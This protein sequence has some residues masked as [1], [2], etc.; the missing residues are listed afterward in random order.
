MAEIIESLLKLAKTDHQRIMLRDHARMILRAANRD[1]PEKS[2][3]N[4][5]E[6]AINRILRCQGNTPPSQ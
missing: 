2:D 1:I 4:A 6:T 3:R 5:V